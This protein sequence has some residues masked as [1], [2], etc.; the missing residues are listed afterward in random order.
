MAINRSTT[1]VGSAFDPKAYH[2]GPAKKLSLDDWTKMMTSMGPGGPP[3]VMDPRC[4][5]VDEGTL[6][7]IRKS[8]RVP[9]DDI[10]YGPKE[11]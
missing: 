7:P 8:Y 10:D 9:V 11:P 4:F 3:P 5:T 2:G 1:S 6:P